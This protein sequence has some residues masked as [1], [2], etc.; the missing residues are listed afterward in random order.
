MLD[1]RSFLKGLGT[2]LGTTTGATATLGQQ[3]GRV[4]RHKSVAGLIVPPMSKVNFGIIGT[5][6]RGQG[7][8]NLLCKIDGAV[9]A[10]LCDTYRPNLDAALL[11]VY[12]N[13]R[14]LPG[15]YGANRDDYKNLL[16]RSDVDVV[17]IATPWEDHARMTIDALNAGKHVLVEVPMAYTLSDLEAIVVAAERNQ[18]NCM[19]LENVCYGRE[20]LMVFNM[21]RKGVLGELIHA[22]AAYI[23]DL[24][25]QMNDIDHGTGSWRTLHYT[26][27]NGNLYPTHGLGP[28][29][30]YMGINRGDK[31]NTIVSVSSLSRSRALYAERHFP[32]G[33]PRRSLKFVAGDM[34]TSIIR[35]ARGRTIMLQWDE[36]LP[37]PYTRHNYIQGTN[38]AWTGYQN[39]F[40]LEVDDAGSET[41]KEGSDLDAVF[42]AHEHPLW[43]KQGQIAQQNGGHGGMDFLMLWRIVYCLRNG[44]PLDQDVY[45]GAA[46]SAVGPLSELSVASGG[47]P[48]TF[49][50][51]TAGEWKTRLPLD[52][53][54]NA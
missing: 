26:K 51:Y 5:G 11:L 17:I 18:K 47:T 4:R 16:A 25:F 14:N 30:Q 39:R 15:S 27:R 6:A 20:E 36:Q 8:V 23:H 37:R 13:G 9:V 41:W 24:R 43:K 48:A 32:E 42:A 50:D 38:G 52:N 33:H 7:H 19:M 31:F 49:P 21:V 34:N 2:L 28:V 44:I 35:T 40:A 53:M 46:W 45:D 1:R 12:Q 54:S 22:D 10:A 3:I 29:A